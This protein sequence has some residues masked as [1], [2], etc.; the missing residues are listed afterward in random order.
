MNRKKKAVLERIESLE[1]ALKKAHEYLDTG[2]HANW[3]GFRPFFAPKIR[4]GREVPPHR[5]WVK[6]VFVP[7]KERALRK[8]EDALERLA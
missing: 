4:D 7:R 3:N 1:E 5:D 6:N 8:A 2:A